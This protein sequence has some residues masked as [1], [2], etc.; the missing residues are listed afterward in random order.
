MPKEERY[1]CFVTTANTV[2]IML[3]VRVIRRYKDKENNVYVMKCIIIETFPGIKNEAYKIGNIVRLD[4]PWQ[5]QKTLED[6]RRVMIMGIFKAR[7]A[8]FYDQPPWS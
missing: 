5:L 3:K 6:A 4:F 1:W 7:D 2:M 8:F